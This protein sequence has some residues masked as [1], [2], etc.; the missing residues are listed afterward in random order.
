MKYTIWKTSKLDPCK[1][2]EVLARTDIFT[3]AMDLVDGGQQIG[4]DP[5]VVTKDGSMDIIYPRD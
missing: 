4:L 3:F 2:V 1:P 5:C